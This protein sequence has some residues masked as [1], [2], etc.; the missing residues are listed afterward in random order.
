[1]LPKALIPEVS[2]R[3]WI[4]RRIYDIIRGQILLS[5]RLQC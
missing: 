5:T 1:M 2:V 4:D 3:T